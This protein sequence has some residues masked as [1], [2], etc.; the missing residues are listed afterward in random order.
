LDSAPL[1]KRIRRDEPWDGGS[2]AKQTG[3]QNPIFIAPADPQIDK[4]L[5]NFTSYV[6]IVGLHTAWAGATPRKLSDFKDPSKTILLV[7]VVN[8]GIHWAE[9]RD[10]Y[11][12]QVS[13]GI[14]PSIGQGISSANPRGAY[15][16]FA[17]GHTEFLPNSTDP[18]KLAEMLSIDGT[19]DQAK[20]E[21]PR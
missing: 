12:G 8:S 16:L 14:N 11:V 17:D 6:A 5:A 18:K 7:E 15:V 13:P 3:I 21:S 4:P 1:F 20:P 2:N 10:L 19:S 9:P